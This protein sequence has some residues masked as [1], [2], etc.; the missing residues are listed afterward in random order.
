VFVG[1]V[2]TDYATRRRSKNAVM[3]GEM[4]RSAAHNSAFYAALGVREGSCCQSNE[5]G[6]ASNNTFHLNLLC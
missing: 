3:P 1:L 5:N 2:T 6:G 4:A